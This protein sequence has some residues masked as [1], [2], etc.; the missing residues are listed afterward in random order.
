[1]HCLERHRQFTEQSMQQIQCLGELALSDDQG[2]S[3]LMVGASHCVWIHQL[4]RTVCRS[5]GVL[6]AVADFAGLVLLSNIN[7]LCELH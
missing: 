7:S 3:P 4:C 1:V 5:G 6:L 2:R